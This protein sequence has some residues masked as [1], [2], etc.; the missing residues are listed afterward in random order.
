MT[1]VFETYYYSLTSALSLDGYN[2]KIAA[3]EDE[4]PILIG[5]NRKR[6]K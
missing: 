6:T 1:A 4:F 2:Q 5:I 3:E